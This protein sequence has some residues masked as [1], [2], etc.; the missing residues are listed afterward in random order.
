MLKDILEGL[1]LKAVRPRVYPGTYAIISHLSLMA[2]DVTNRSSASWKKAQHIFIKSLQPDGGEGL[3]PYWREF[4]TS[5]PDGN[6][7]SQ[8]LYVS[9]GSGVYKK[10]DGS[11]NLVQTGT[12]ENVV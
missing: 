2:E 5:E 1:N 8:F 11:S 6:H 7:N 9:I 10:F 3:L 4:M 12:L